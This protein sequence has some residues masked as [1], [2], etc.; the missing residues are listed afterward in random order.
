MGAFNYLPVFSPWLP[1]LAITLFLCIVIIPKFQEIFYDLLE[2][3]P[4][5]LA[6]RMVIT[7]TKTLL[8]LGAL[9][10]VLGILLLLLG[11]ARR[12]WPSAY[13]RTIKVLSDRCL[14][15]L[16]WR[17]KRMQ[18]DFSAM[19]A[20]LLD[21]GVPEPEAVTLAAQST[22]NHVFVIRSQRV[23]GQLQRGEKLA[24]CHPGH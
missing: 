3:E 17:H 11:R 15:C 14:F 23:I 5:P 18:R 2:A 10:A 7:Y 4:L 1:L 13:S 8:E 12:R 22:G 20:I 19:L 16:P 9:I 6:T 21:A 24:D